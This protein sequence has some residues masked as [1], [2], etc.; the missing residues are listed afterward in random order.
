L[1]YLTGMRQSALL[2]TGGRKRQGEF[3]MRESS[4]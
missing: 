4:F 3:Q 1:I 2:A